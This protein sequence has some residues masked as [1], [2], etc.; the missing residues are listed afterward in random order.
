[1]KINFFPELTAAPEK[2]AASIAYAKSLGLPEIADAARPP[3]A[4]VAGGPSVARRI[5][6]LWNWAGDIWVCGTAYPWARSKGLDA[7]FFCVDQ[8]NDVAPFAEGAKHAILA[9]CSDPSTFDALRGA[10]VEIFDLYNGSG[11]VTHGTSTAS[12]TF[13]LSLRMGYRSVTYFGCESSYEGASHAYHHDTPQFEIRV[14]CGG[15]LFDTN[16]SLL[17]QVEHMAEIIRTFPMFFRERSG[18]L[19]RA[20]IANPEFDITHGSQDL[21]DHIFKKA[22]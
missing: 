12:S 2:T 9:T 20:M 5:E 16:A 11:G 10:K 7:T 15:E 4:V 1:M 6:D 21:H 17:M 18:G 19:L 13:E 14:V 8:A 3:L 22:A